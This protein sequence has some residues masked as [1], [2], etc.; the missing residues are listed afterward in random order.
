MSVSSIYIL[1]EY[2]KHLINCYVLNP[3]MFYSC[4]I[5]KQK[6]IKTSNISNGKWKIT[7]NKRSTYGILYK[8][9][10]EIIEN[11]LLQLNNNILLVEK[12][13]TKA[14]Q[15]AIITLIPKKGDLKD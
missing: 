13:T 5:K 4:C 15:E 11:D 10:Y 8:T 2:L 12:N 7:R 6:W 14:M 9:F 3:I 1:P